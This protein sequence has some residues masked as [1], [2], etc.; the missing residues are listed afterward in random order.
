MRPARSSSCAAPTTRPRAA[1]MPPT[2]GAPRQR[3]T[4]SPPGTRCRQRCVC[5]SRSSARPDPGA[6]GDLM[7]DLHQPPESPRRGCLRGA[8]RGASRSAR[9]CSSSGLATSVSIPTRRRPRPGLQSHRELAIAGP[10]SRQRGSPDTLMGAGIDQP[11]MLPGS[12]S[13]CWLYSGGVS[14]D[15]GSVLTRMT[16][17]QLIND[18]PAPMLSRLATNAPVDARPRPATNGVVSISPDICCCGNE[19]ALGTGAERFVT[20]KE[21]FHLETVDV[22][23]PWGEPVTA[24]WMVGPGVHA[25]GHEH[26]DDEAPGAGTAIDPVCGMTVAPPLA[27]EKGLHSR[28]RDTDYFF[29]GK[30]CKLEFDD[31]PERYLDPSYNALD[32]AADRR[33]CSQ[34]LTHPPDHCHTSASARCVAAG[35]PGMLDPCPSPSRQASHRHLLESAFRPRR[36]QRRLELEGLSA[37]RDYQRR[38]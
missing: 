18:G 3:C 31:D 29:C 24:A 25:D 38:A 34:D 21:G 15:G 36:C 37:Y 12:R 8:R 33:G 4:G 16:R 22:S 10:G 6:D 19:F 26:A 20:P 14:T 23:V 7:A 17:K 9:L 28:F 35:N 11:S 32:V 27:I 30:G 5:T 1:V 13:R 2:G